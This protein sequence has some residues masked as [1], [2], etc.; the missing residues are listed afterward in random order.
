MHFMVI[1]CVF[2]REKLRIF[3]SHAHPK[4]RDRRGVK[5]PR[6]HLVSIVAWLHQVLP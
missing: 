3:A 6:F 4:Y 1:K 2:G 5:A